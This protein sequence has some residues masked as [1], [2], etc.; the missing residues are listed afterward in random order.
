MTLGKAV[1]EHRQ[2]LRAATLAL[3]VPVGVPELLAL[4]PAGFES[5]HLHL[6]AAIRG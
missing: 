5:Q 3:S 6:P 1:G 2:L 4:R